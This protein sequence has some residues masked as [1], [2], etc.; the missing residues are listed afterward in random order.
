MIAMSSIMDKFTEDAARGE[1]EAMTAVA[2]SF[3]IAPE[4]RAAFSTM[5]HSNFATVFPSE[6]VTAGQVMDS[7][8]ELM[9]QDQRLSKYVA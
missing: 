8:V 6:N 1:G 9:K 4:D 2:V 7:L 5:V 3:G